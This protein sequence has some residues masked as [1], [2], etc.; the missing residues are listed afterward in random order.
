M[1]VGQRLFVAVVPAVIG[2]IAVAGLAYW[3]QYARTAPLAVIVVGAIATTAS[4]WMAWYNTRYVARRISDLAERTTRN[5]DSD[6]GSSETGRSLGAGTGPAGADELDAIE[7]T[8]HRLSGAVSRARGEGAL[9][10]RAAVARATEYAAIAADIVSVMR[11]RLEEAELPLHVLLS[12]PFGA[13]NENQEELLTAARA[14]VG[15]ADEEVRLLNSLLDLDRGRIHAMPQAIGLAEMLRPTLA[16]IE[17]RARD[18][19]VDFR[20]RVSGA[21]PR[22]V[23]DPVQIQAALVTI[24]SDVVSRTPA[25]GEVGVQAGECQAGTM[26][27]VIT[28]RVAVRRSV[29]SLGARVAQRLV[30]LQHGSMVEETDCTVVELPG[31]SLMAVRDPPDTLRDGDM[32]SVP[33]GWD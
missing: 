22:A 1:R 10:E 2:V 16:I 4:L 23:A 9:R 32:K 28:H 17:A 18:A 15:A 5:S 19:R 14:A 26:Q 25:G 21:A 12:S 6:G 29:A 20:V 8:V 7:T 11:A 3:G 24:L 33:V 13:L 27:I 31:E 30:A